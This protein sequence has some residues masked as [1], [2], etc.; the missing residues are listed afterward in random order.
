MMVHQFSLT[1]KKTSM[2]ADSKNLAITWLV[3][4]NSIHINVN[5]N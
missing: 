4:F 2:Y 1:C 3:N 5:L